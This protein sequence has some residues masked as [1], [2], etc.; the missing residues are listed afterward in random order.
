VLLQPEKINTSVNK[1]TR[2]I[3]I[4]FKFGLKWFF[5]KKIV[6]ILG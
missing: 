3:E 6:V 2:I 4:G 1:I 5:Q